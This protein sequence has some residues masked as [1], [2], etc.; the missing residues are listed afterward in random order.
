MIGAQIST[1][2]PRYERHGKM[3]AINDTHSDSLLSI[4]RGAIAVSAKKIARPIKIAR[5]L[6]HTAVLSMMNIF[7]EFFHV[8]LL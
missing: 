5:F 8:E 7:K 1:A 3:L 6:S 4:F 2:T